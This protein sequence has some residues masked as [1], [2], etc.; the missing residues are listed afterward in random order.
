MRGR[1]TGWCGG[2]PGS[3]QEEHPAGRP[4]PAFDVVDGQADV[5]AVIA[6]I[7]QRKPIRRKDREYHRTRPPFGDPWDVPRFPPLV[8]EKVQDEVTDLVGADGGEECGSKTK[9]AR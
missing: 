3:T 5:G 7:R 1:R 2:R 6:V 9:P 4:R 8:V